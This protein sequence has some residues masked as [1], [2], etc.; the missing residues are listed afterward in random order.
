MRIASTTGPIARPVLTVGRVQIIDE[1]GELDRRIN[2]F[3]PIVARHKELKEEISGW[4]NALPGD[5]TAVAEG[6]LYTI[7]I[8][9]KDNRRTITDIPR[10]FQLLKK[11]VGLESLLGLITIPLKVI[12]AHVSIVNQLSIVKQE[13]TGPR[14]IIPV[15]KAPIEAAQQAA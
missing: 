15:A 9:K 4:Y 1:F 2:E 3:K 11:A 6:K 13:R 10:T 5:Q 8:G 12:D 7:Q 14:D